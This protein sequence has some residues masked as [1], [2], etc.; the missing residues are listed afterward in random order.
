MQPPMPRLAMKTPF[1]SILITPVLFA[2]AVFSQAGTFSA[3]FNS[4]SL[5]ANMT[6]YGTA[7]IQPSG[8]F[9]NSGYLQ[10]T[11]VASEG[12]AAVLLSDLD[13]GTP[14]VSFTAQFKVQLGNNLTYPADGMSFNFAPD[15]PAGT[16]PQTPLGAT[17]IGAEEGAG[18]GYTIEFD[19]YNNGAPDS[20]PSIGVKVGGAFGDH[21]TYDGNEFADAIVPTMTPVPEA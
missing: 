15:L 16:Y 2:S 20:A 14:I 18:T 8:G 19:T 4:G 3:D 21:G 6:A 1:L 9:T 13:N 5:P 10:L 11:T 7:S 17:T 12:D